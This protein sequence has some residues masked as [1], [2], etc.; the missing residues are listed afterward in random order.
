[1]TL[2]RKLLIA[3][4]LVGTGFGVALLLGKPAYVGPAA[5]F[6]TTLPQSLS[7]AATRTTSAIS[8]WI[9]GGATLVPDP[10][11][12]VET[13]TPC[14]ARLDIAPFESQQVPAAEAKFE[15]MNEFA[16]NSAYSVPINYPPREQASSSIASPQAR[17]R[18]EAPRPYGNEPRSPVTIRRTPFV[19]LEESAVPVDSESDA[20][21]DWSA[22]HLLPADYAL[23][24]AAPE[25]TQTLNLRERP[26]ADAVSPT[27]AS[28]PA[29]NEDSDAPRTH[30]VVDGDSLEKLA[31]RYLNDPHRGD[32]IFELNRQLLASPDLLPIG[33]E[34]TIPERLTASSWNRQGRTTGSSIGSDVR[35]AASSSLVP[36]RPLAHDDAIIP[37]ARLAAPQAVE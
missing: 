7:P 24:R 37:Q 23:G 35:Q 8:G 14:P 34:L 28:A 6:S 32:E 20:K 36:L 27:A 15:P 5:A 12:L 18:N 19:E 29:N 10:D 25:S 30:V 17:L 16:G 2:F 4:A 11:P 9:V 1:M 13:K 26:P 21:P 31:G 33:I 3:S 22:P